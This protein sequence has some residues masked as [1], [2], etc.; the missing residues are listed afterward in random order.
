MARTRED[1]LKDCDPSEGA[2]YVKV[3]GAVEGLAERLGDP[4]PKDESDL[5]APLEETPLRLRFTFS[6]GKGWSL[7]LQHPKLPN[8]A[9]LLWGFPSKGVDESKVTNGV[10]TLAK[11][12]RDAKIAA[13]DIDAFGSDLTRADFEKVGQ[14]SWR[15]IAAGRSDGVSA[16]FDHTMNVDALVLAIHR[17][18]ARVEKYP[19][20]VPATPAATAVA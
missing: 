12:L 7:K 17:M 8:V 11:P 2:A 15:T 5:G 19:S 13:P 3:F 20:R 16:T 1:F 9:P 6:D 14:Q 10:C 4:A 18:I